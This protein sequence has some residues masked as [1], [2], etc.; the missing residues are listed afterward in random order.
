MS[1]AYSW[2]MAPRPLSAASFST[3]RRT[4]STRAGSAGCRCS[5][6]M[7]NS[8]AAAAGRASSSPSP[9]CTSNASGT[10]ATGWCA[11]RRFARAAAATWGMYSRMGHDPPVS[12]IASI[13]C[14]SV[15]LRPGRRFRTSS[16]GARR[17]GPPTQGIET[18][19]VGQGFARKQRFDEAEL[20]QIAYAARVEDAVQ[21]VH[22]VLDY[23][24]MKVVHAS[25][26]GLALGVY[27]GIS[28][29]A[30]PWDHPSHAGY[31]ETSLPTVLH[32]VAEGGQLGV[33]QHGV[34]HRCGLRVARIVVHA[35]NHHAQA[36]AYLRR[37]KSRPIEILHRVPHIGDQV[38][39][40]WGAELPNRFGHRQ[41]PRIAHLQNFAYCHDC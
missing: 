6:P 19:V 12:D 4:A 13:Q 22:L 14:R 34:G 24:G 27:A 8:I 33:D 11:S 29:V 18:L 31:R 28:Q 35:E 17:K 32:L 25:V 9:R 15:S 20:G 40:R 23:P 37:G 41:E 10:R 30:E 3:T 39:E 21:M 2:N 16:S 36:H 5:G 38:F 26:D 7:P 1:A